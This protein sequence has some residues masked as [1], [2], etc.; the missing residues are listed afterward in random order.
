MNL[1]IFHLKKLR[2]LFYMRKLITEAYIPLAEFIILLYIAYNI[3]YIIYHYHISLYIYII[4]FVSHSTNP[5]YFVFF[6]NKYFKMK[7]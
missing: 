3:I 1:E 2:S 7:F 5:I 6:L 4:I